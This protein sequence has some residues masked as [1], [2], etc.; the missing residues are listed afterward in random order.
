LAGDRGEVAAFDER[1]TDPGRRQRSRSD[2]TIDAAAND[3]DLNGRTVEFV[4]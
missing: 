3:G 2:R 1:A 4:E